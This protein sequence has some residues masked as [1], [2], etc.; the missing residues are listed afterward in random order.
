M[1]CSCPKCAA[2]IQVDLANIPADGAYTPCPECKSR[3][4]VNRESYA[5]RALRK[6]GA[7]YCDKCSKELTHAIVCTDCGCMYPDYWLVQAAKPVKRKLEKAEFSLSFSP[8]P[9]R[10]TQIYTY[11]QQ[12]P[13]KS[14]KSLL[15]GVFLLVLVVSLAVAG[16]AA[17][18]NM[19]AEKRYAKYFIVA[20]YEIKGGA[21]RGLEQCAKITTDWKAKMDAG[22]SF[23]AHLS[24]DDEARSSKLKD[25]IDT[26]MQQLN[27]PPQKFSKVNESI[28]KLY[29]AYASLYSL[30]LAPPGNL[31]SFTDRVGKS[32]N[33]YKLAIQ[34]LKANLPGD[35]SEK[36]AKAK[37]KYKSLQDL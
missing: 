14:L 37:T 21:D 26:V 34:E 15:V 3:F 33:D 24:P 35:L 7:L 6:D 4:W 32:Q 9:A 16:I 10:Q 28:V 12:T 20:L 27:K 31:Q 30:T 29:G 17:F 22:Q 2:D 13:Q 19:Q 18:R 1:T 23:F 8:K 11:T 36:I 25:E 5:R